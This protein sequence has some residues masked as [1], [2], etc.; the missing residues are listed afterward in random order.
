[1]DVNVLGPLEIRGRGGRE[2][3]LPAGRE[4]SLF[5]LLLIHRGEVVSTDRIIDALWGSRPPGAAMKAVQGYVSHLRRVLDPGDATRVLVTQAPGY[6]LLTDAIV[7][8]ATR[9]EQ[10]AG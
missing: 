1:M 2:I 9:F 6:A 8:D 4:R 3:K 5:V 10:L 7:V